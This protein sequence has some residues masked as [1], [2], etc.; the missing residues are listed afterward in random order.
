MGRKIK[1]CNFG[2]YDPNYPRNSIF[3]KSLKNIG[4][5]VIQCND[6]SGEIKNYL[7]L[8]DSFI[9]QGK[10]S[11]ILFVGVLGHYDVPLAWLLAKLF[12]K[13]L[14]FNT[15]ISLYDTYVED[16]KQTNKHSLE[17]IKFFFWD[18]ISTHLADKVI[19]DTKTHAD[20][21]I[22]KFRLDKSKV[23][24]VYVGTD[25]EIF[26]PVDKKKTRQGIVE[27]HGSFRPLH[28]VDFIV[29]A[30][31]ILKNKNIHFKILGNGDTYHEVKELVDKLNLKNIT[32]FPRTNMSGLRSFIGSSDISLGIFGNTEKASRVIPNKVFEAIAMKKPVITMDS[33]AIREVFTPN[34]NIVLVNNKTPGELAAAIEG[35]LEDNKFY[36][37]ISNESY[38]LYKQQFTPK[39]LTES[40][41]KAISCG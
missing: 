7:N 19:L 21:F 14:I 16:R 28:G 3:L 12:R 1:I 23:V 27:F 18:F 30:A 36:N 38:A 10:D 8:L 40:L 4:L 24:Y 26:Y 13:K 29:K 33:P 32:L 11:D 2:S 22:K 20:Y 15:F 25:D 6:R 35:L 37:L 5:E 34:K 39:K 17:A 9:K 41:L 31:N